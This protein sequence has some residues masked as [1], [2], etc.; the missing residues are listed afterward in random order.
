[1]KEAK[2][3]ELMDN[4]GE[5]VG[6]KGEYIKSRLASGTYPRPSQTKR[7]GAVGTCCAAVLFAP[8]V[9]PQKNVCAC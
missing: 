4:K 9:C 5:I 6:E 1:M 3:G 7:G 2:K 8:T